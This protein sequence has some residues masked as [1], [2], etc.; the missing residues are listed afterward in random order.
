MTTTAPNPDIV[1]KNLD[2]NLA[3]VKA[4]ISRTDSKASLLLA[5]DGAVLVGIASLADKQLPLVTQI[6]GGLAALALVVAADLLLR[7]VRPRLGR[8]S[9]PGS[10]PLLRGVRPRL[11][12][13]FAPGSFPH[14]A[15]LSLDGLREAM[16]HDHRL[17]NLSVL[18]G[19]AV[20]KYTALT[21]A[22][23]LLRAALALLV[24]AA[25]AALAFG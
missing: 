14:L 19:L 13:T 16:A 9:A 25:V 2:A 3:D 6:I 7:G 5:F 23:D 20:A 4:Q 17:A 21:R 18:S 11:A 8:T 1:D 15:K 24:V 12:R 22:V 10:F